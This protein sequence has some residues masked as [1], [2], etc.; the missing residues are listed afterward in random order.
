MEVKIKSEDVKNRK[1]EYEI[2]GDI[3]VQNIDL[4]AAKMKDAVSAC[5]VLTVNLKQI[6]GFDVAAFQFFYSLKNSFIRDKKCLTVKCGLSNE[7]SQLLL[8]CGIKDLAETL[9]YKNEN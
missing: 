9:S 7:V 4:L 6:T 5:D 3:S 1:R 2:S 8:N